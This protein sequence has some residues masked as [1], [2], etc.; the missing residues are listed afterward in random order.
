MLTSGNDLV[1]G[2]DE[3]KVW[4]VRHD[5]FRERGELHALLPKFVDLLHDF[6]DRALAAIEDGTQLD[7]RGFHSS[8]GM[9]I[10]WLRL[11]SRP[12]LSNHCHDSNTPPAV[13]LLDDGVGRCLLGSNTMVQ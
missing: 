9:L 6:V 7:R 1:G 12:L 13:N 11:R 8:H 3:R 10:G 5:G 2:L 4:V